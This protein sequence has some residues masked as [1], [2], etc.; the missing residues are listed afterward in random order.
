MV[1]RTVGSHAKLL[2]CP[3]GRVDTERPPRT[4]D[5]GQQTE[6][7]NNQQRRAL[8]IGAL[9]AVERSGAASRGR[10]ILRSGLGEVG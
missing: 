4:A 6:C 1:C 5:E 9:C 8:P 7:A 2:S 3:R 10:L